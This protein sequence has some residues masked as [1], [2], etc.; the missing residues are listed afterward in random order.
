MVN[1]TESF[2]GDGKNE[3]G[4]VTGSFIHGYFPILSCDMKGLVLV[5]NIDLYC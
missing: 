1:F 4:L 2:S 5:L 3:V